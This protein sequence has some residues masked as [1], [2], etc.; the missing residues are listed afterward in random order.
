MDDKENKPAEGKSDELEKN[1]GETQEKK[2][3]AKRST[4]GNYWDTHPHIVITGGAEELNKP[5]RGNGGSLLA[6]PKPPANFSEKLHL[7]SEQIAKSTAKALE[8]AVKKTEADKAAKIKAEAQAQAKAKAEQEAV[9]AKMKK[10]SEDRLQKNREADARRETDRKQAEADR[11][12]AETEHQAAEKAKAEIKAKAA[13]ESKAKA[14]AIIKARKERFSKAGVKPAPSYTAQMVAQ[15]NTAL[16]APDALVLNQTPGSAQ[17]T[18]AGQGVWTA[19][20]EIAGNLSHWF[21][22]AL[23]KLSVP[24]VSAGALRLSVATLLLH[25]EPAGKG[26][27][28]VPG[29]DLEAMFAL[30]ARH[31]AEAGV[32]IEPGSKSIELPVRGSLVHSEG[33]LTLGLLKTGPG[34]AKAVQV[35][36]AVRDAA[37][38]LD[39][40][41]VP[42]MAGIPERHILINPAP[43]HPATP[44]HT[45]TPVMGPVTPVHTGTAVKPVQPLMVT[46]TPVETLSGIHDFIYWRPDASGTGVEPVYV[47]LS[48]NPRKLPGIVTGKGEGIGEKWLNDANKNVG[49]PIP[50]RIADKL[51]GR[52]FSTFDTF[53]KAFWTEVGKDPELLK[54]FKNRNKTLV[55]KGQSS[56][57]CESEYADKRQRFELHH[58]KRVVDGGAVYD[59]DNIRVVTPKR[60]IEIHRGNK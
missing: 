8:E 49:V 28:K 44:S 5:G 33:Q 32:K 24:E 21:N 59:I 41:T 38:G 11:K 36:T 20:D 51:Q 56:F 43:S 30:N 7:E 47:M 60:H 18:L 26:S 22:Q 23:S 58:I 34:V 40:I 48:Q 6:Q 52:K 14:D 9:T 25:S 57:V 55:K 50:A 27:D 31:L 42:A 45:G 35:L 12:K 10:E 1:T 46:T 29:R 2:S 13:V 16:K 54:Q 17:L 15:A 53:R 4:G 37:T 3:R 19:T 39:K